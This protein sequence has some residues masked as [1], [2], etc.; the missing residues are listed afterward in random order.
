MKRAFTLIELLVVIAIIAILAAILFPVFAQAKAAAK[1]AASLSNIKQMA[2]ASLMYSGDADDTNIPAGIWGSGDPDALNPTTSRYATW[3]LLVDPYSKNIDIYSSPLGNSST[4]AGEV[5]RRTGTRFMSYGYN[6]T[7]LMQFQ[8]GGSPTS[9]NYTSATSFAKPAETVMYAEHVSRGNQSN[10]AQWYMG[11]NTAV[12]LGL[13]ETPACYFDP[14]MYCL[15]G[16]GNDG[17]S[18]DGIT[19]VEEGKYTGSNA[20]RK[21][22]Q[23]PVAWLDG[24]V[25]SMAPGNLASGTNWKNLPTTGMPNNDIVINDYDKYLWDDK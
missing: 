14:Y 4:M 19:K 23:I 22:G 1:G 11:G 21:S 15:D 10:A 12:N 20:P 16:W 24:H 17:L 8:I 13:A 25:K 7:Y 2:L 9:L 18:S 5:K 3:A 6:Y